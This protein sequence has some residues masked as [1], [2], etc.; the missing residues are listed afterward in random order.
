MLPVGVGR[1]F[2]DEC[3]KFGNGDAITVGEGN[4][5]NSIALIDR[6]RSRYPRLQLPMLR[7]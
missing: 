3:D 5:F 6:C 1:S 4:P 7:L 2:V